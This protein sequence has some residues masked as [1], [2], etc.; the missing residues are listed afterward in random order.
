M[1]EVTVGGRV[2]YCDEFARDHDALVT[3]VWGPNCV[4]VVFVTS[5]EDRKDQYG[6]QIMRR[7]L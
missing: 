5:D 4:N 7:R 2:V 3:A 6:R 1:T